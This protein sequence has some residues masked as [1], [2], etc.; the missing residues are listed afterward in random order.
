MYPDQNA[1]EMRLDLTAKGQWGFNRPMQ[2]SEQFSL[3]GLDQVSA[4]VADTFS[5]DQGVTL[6]GEL[7]RSFG[8]AQDGWSATLMRGA[9]R[10]A[11]GNLL[12]VHYGRHHTES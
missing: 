8:I 10:R 11:I 12:R 9:L 3:D 2:S 4:F 6:R 1:W 7:A 5:V